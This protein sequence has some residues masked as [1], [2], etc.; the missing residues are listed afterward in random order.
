MTPSCIHRVGSCGLPQ[1]I[2]RISV[3]RLSK[4]TLLYILIMACV[5]NCIS[6]QILSIM[7]C[8]VHRGNELAG[9]TNCE[10]FNLSRGSPRVSLDWAYLHTSIVNKQSWWSKSTWTTYLFMGRTHTHIP[11]IIYV[12]IAFHGNTKYVILI[13][14]LKWV[15][16]A[17]NVPILVKML[18]CWTFTTYTAWKPNDSHQLLMVS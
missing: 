18:I 5:Q 12:A 1:P 3:I 14:M 13:G 15:N 9:W 16:T 6:S 7:S 11:L 8:T 10:D 4:N 2:A 17:S